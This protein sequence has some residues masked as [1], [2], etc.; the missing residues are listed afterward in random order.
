MRLDALTGL[1]WWAALAVFAYH[2]ENLVEFPA[3]IARWL[4]WGYLG[5]TFFFVLSGFVLTWSMRPGTSRTTF[6][7]RRISRIYPL[8]LVALV[9]AIPV[10]YSLHPDPAQWWVKQ[11]SLPVIAL[12]VVVLQ[13]WWRDPVILFSGNP[14]AW[15]LTAEFFFYALHPFLAAM[16]W[17]VRR[18][19]AF[20]AVGAIAALSLVA[21]IAAIAWPAG[22]F[23]NLPWP[24]LRMNEFALGMALAWAM[25]WGFAARVPPWFVAAGATAAF[26][27]LTYLPSLGGIGQWVPEVA[28]AIS[29][30][31]IVSVASRE[32]AGGARW[33]RWRPIVV[34]GEWSFAFY[35]IHATILYA[36]RE[37]GG[38]QPW[39]APT[40]VTVVALAAVAIAGAGALH[41]LVERPVESRLRRV[42][43]AAPRPR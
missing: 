4:Q 20:V 3:F 39:G 37:A 14:A 6:Y 27:A 40:A 10:F 31:A 2:C 42:W 29:A 32:M 18:R 5:V 34:L 21:R 33:L 17:R 38:F 13:G 41:T 23:A 36:V 25:R 7:W 26:A 35:L 19:G 12:S 8:H 1:R 43:P 9:L 11:W 16:L 22:W 28:T 30:L 15:T 24:V